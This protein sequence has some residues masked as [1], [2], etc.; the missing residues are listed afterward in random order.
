MYKCT[1]PECGITV[2]D[3]LMESKVVRAGSKLYCKKCGEPVEHVADAPKQNG[4]MQG[5]QAI[6]NS[7]SENHIYTGDNSGNTNTTNINIKN[8]PD[9]DAITEAFG[10]IQEQTADS[11]MKFMKDAAAHGKDDKLFSEDWGEIDKSNACTCNSCGKMVPSQ[12]YDH[13]QHLCVNCLFKKASKL[14]DKNLWDEAADEFKRVEMISTAKML[15]EIQEAIG[16]CYFM[17]D[18]KKK[19]KKYLALAETPV[20]YYVLGFCFLEEDTDQAIRNFTKAAEKDV[21]PAQE[22]LKDYYLKGK[23]LEKAEIWLLKLAKAGDILS[24]F[25]LAN[26]YLIYADAR[27][28]KNKDAAQEYYKKAAEWLEKVAQKDIDIAKY[29]L[30]D[31]LLNGNGTAKNTTRAIELMTQAAE[32][33]FIASQYNLA[34]IFEEGKYGVE[35]NYEK[36]LY[37]YKK[38]A[39]QKQDQNI[40]VVAMYKVG[41][42]YQEGKGVARNYQEAANWLKK[43]AMKNHVQAQ[44]TLGTICKD[45]LNDWDEAA[46][47]L[48]KAS[49]A[50]NIEAKYELGSLY[51][52][53][54]AK[55][56]ER[57]LEAIT[58]LTVAADNGHAEA[59]MKIAQCHE[60]DGSYTLAQNYYQKAADKGN[61]QAQEILDERFSGKTFAEKWRK[62]AGSPIWGIIGSGLSK[63]KGCLPLI[64][65]AVVI[66][67]AVNMC[68]KACQSCT[69]T[70]S[71]AS[72]IYKQ[73]IF[74]KQEV[75][76]P[77]H[78]PTG[79][80]QLN[81]DIKALFR[82]NYIN[83]GNK[84]LSGDFQLHFIITKEGRAIVDSKSI[85]I[86]NKD[87]VRVMVEVMNHLPKQWQPAKKNSEY[88]NQYVDITIHF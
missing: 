86:E 81:K 88:V 79:I 28:E 31:L 20:S 85:P 1:N 47:W 41:Q 27:K 66:L 42:F 8:G 25:Q 43:A 49:K 75:D 72:D 3:D 46:K 69:G 17:D 58:L 13:Q 65:G 71:S 60:E 87:V 35:A 78:Y 54:S 5:A 51:L 19:A 26:V 24:Q 14:M 36:S 48:S 73:D 29:Q 84:S 74:T 7:N 56:P 45:K 67:F 44:A 9:I 23:D 6:M 62:F 15:P 39:E 55:N 82:D 83:R 63:M 68:N 77:A 37:W 11:F 12:H 53:Q 61:G 59:M 30:G 57:K 70:D 33:G 22:W 2:P 34:T 38:V 76:E 64:I 10:R 40:A 21:S 16:I 18:D 32:N 4:T 50:G 52:M 80:K